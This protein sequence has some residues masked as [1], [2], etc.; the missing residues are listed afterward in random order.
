MVRLMGFLSSMAM[1]AGAAFTV[2]FAN[3]VGNGMST[4]ALNGRTVASIISER[5]GGV[6]Q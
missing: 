6:V 2:L 3:A 1:G 4:Y 5:T